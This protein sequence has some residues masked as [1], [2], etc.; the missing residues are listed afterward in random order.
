MQIHLWL[1]TSYASWI[2]ENGIAFIFTTGHSQHA[3]Y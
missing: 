2:Y 1:S 3:F